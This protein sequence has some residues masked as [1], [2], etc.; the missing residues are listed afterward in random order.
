M[1]S[2]ARILITTILAI[3]IIFAFSGCSEEAGIPILTE[4][5][6]SY[7]ELKAKVDVFDQVYANYWD[8]NEDELKVLTGEGESPLGNSCY[9][10]YVTNIEGKN[11][12]DTVKS[13]T[14]YITNDQG[15][16]WVDEYFA[17]DNATLFIARTTVPADN[18]LG[19]ITKYIYVDNTLYIIDEEESTLT[20]VEK[21][22]TLDLYLTF[23]DLT[24]LYGG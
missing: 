21:A 4:S 11:K 2:K 8:N 17:V 22:D 7:E 10:Q 13:C 16:S 6:P 20:P 3:L 19:E 23:S 12:A 14:L 9:Y 24:E 15:E 5:G 1:R 18:S